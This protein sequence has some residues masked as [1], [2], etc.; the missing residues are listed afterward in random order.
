MSSGATPLTANGSEVS[1]AP[2]LAPGSTVVYSVTNNCGFTDE[3]VV[4]TDS[5]FLASILPNNPAI[6]ATEQVLFC[7]H[8]H[9]RAI[10]PTMESV[11]YLNDP[12]AQLLFM[13]TQPKHHLYSNHHQHPIGLRSYGIGNSYFFVANGQRH[14]HRRTR[15]RLCWHSRTVI[16]NRRKHCQP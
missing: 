5:P 8:K 7:K 10:T 2:Q 9:P 13:P 16:I 4:T 6:C 12:T 1:L 15:Y 14:C 11:N 3:I